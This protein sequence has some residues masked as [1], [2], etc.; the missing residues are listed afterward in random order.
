MNQDIQKLNERFKSEKKNI[1][2]YIEFME[3]NIGLPTISNLTSYIEELN[4]YIEFEYPNE[5]DDEILTLVE[6]KNIYRNYLDKLNELEDR[7]NFYNSELDKIK[8]SKYYDE[9]DLND[10]EESI[11]I[12]IYDHGYY[13]FF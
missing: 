8:D 1:M 5:S 4:N 6:S 9:N 10:V 12:Y 7:I 2:S 11:V 13:D 3:E